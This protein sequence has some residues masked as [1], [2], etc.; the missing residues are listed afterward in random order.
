ME[1]SNLLVIFFAVVL[2]FVFSFVLGEEALTS[3]NL[4]FGILSTL[5]YLVCIAVAVLLTFT[6]MREGGSLAVFYGIFG[7]VVFIITI[8]YLTRVGVNINLW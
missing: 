7:S 3:G 8:W 2:M 1:S 5:G 4:F 6:I